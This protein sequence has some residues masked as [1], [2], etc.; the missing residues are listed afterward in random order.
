M[1]ARSIMYTLVGCYYTFDGEMLEIQYCSQ[2]V[3]TL[4]PTRIQYKICLE[5]VNAKNDKIIN[6]LSSTTRLMLFNLHT[7]YSC[8]LRVHQSK[9]PS[10]HLPSFLSFTHSRHLCTLFRSPV[11]FSLLTLMREPSNLRCFCGNFLFSEANNNLSL[12]SIYWI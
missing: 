12:H 9:P 8:S 10:A 2:N 1:C 11:Q 7:L 3:Q 5:M 4:H 6:N